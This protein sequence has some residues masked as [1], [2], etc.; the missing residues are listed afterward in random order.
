MCG[1]ED[2]LSISYYYYC[3]LLIRTQRSVLNEQ[4]REYCYSAVC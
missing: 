4:M 2:V 1:P 3:I